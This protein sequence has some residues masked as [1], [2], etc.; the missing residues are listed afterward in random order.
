MLFKKALLCVC[1]DAYIRTCTQA[2]ITVGQ[3]VTMVTARTYLRIFV[4]TNI[5]THIYTYK[6]IFT[7]GSVFGGQAVS[8]VK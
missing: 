1:I 6:H 4:Y 7:V 5:H 2:R 3:A 8:V